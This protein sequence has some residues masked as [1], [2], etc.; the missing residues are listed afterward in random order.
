[1]KTLEREE[2][3][4]EAQR[5]TF[6]PK[7]VL[8]QVVISALAISPDGESVVYVN[9]TIENNKY[10]R[11]LW[12]TTFKG[13]EPGQL[14]AANASDMRPR[15]SPDGKQ[16]LFI[17]DRSGKPQAWIIPTSGGEARQVTDLPSG[18]AAAEWS[19]DGTKLLLG[20]G[21]GV[22]RFIVGKDDDPTARKIRDYTWRFDG[23][24]IRDE[25][26]SLWIT[27]V[28]D[29]KPVRITDPDYGVDAFAWSPDG[30]SVAFMADRSE[31]RGLEEIDSLWIMQID[32]GEPREVA[33]LKGGLL[34]MSWAPGNEI[35]FSGTD[36]PG[37]PGWAD[38]E[39]HVTD[40]SG[41]TSRRLAGDRN[42]NVQVTSYGDY[43]DSE[44][45]APAA[46]AWEDPD[47]IVT[48]VSTRGYSH[49]YRFGLDGKVEALATPDATCSSIATGGGRIAVIAATA[50]HPND[51]FAVE[52]GKLRRLT[53]DGSRWYGPFA[54]SSEHLRI[55]HEDG[56]DIDAWLVPANGSRTKAP[57][58]IDVH[59]GPN[60]SFGPT[61]WLE[62]NALADAGI[63][64]IWSNPR[65][66][67]S[68]GEKFAKDLEGA[69]G[70]P[71]GSDLL[72]IVDWA[73]GEGLADRK[74]LGIMGLSYG[75]FM[76]NWMLANHPGVFAAAVSENPVTDLLGEWA[77][78]DFGRYIG[79][80]AI[81]VQNPWDDID[82][83]ITRS[84]FFK[85]HQNHAPLLLLQGE[86]DMRCPPGNSD[87]VFHIL[88]TL[89]REVEMIR[90]PQESHLMLA[91]ARPDRRVDRLERIVG[92]FTKYLGSAAGD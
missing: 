51:V 81:E 50:D 16:L 82:K 28:D 15:F 9:R 80:R 85:M 17:S 68:Y 53:E 74:K 13:G 69:W 44:Q 60:A 66:S 33:R 18:V 3:T 54:R 30:K 1:M 26:A 65:G 83:F 43:Q 40:P 7:D 62:M 63:H 77:T 37:S 32:G 79:R 48:L 47:N 76:T 70:D 59:G 6:Q 23:A 24:G 35:A 84:P 8:K 91:L 19:P 52:G 87:M 49:P 75:G 41:K 4:Q 88:R 25:Y 90:Y 27:D 55:K 20:G 92:W 22:K 29:P 61:P 10:A 58:V 73:V 11:R 46:I 72:T 57:L 89:G 78:S 42:L 39:L 36:Q 31:T 71:D 14:T 86:N 67:V 34:M 45:F 12:R 2:G 64:V 56:H 5:E 21:S 38:I